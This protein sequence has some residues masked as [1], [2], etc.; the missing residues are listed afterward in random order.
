MLYKIAPD[1][2][3]W[4]FHSGI[5]S[6]ILDLQDFVLLGNWTITATY[7]HRVSPPLRAHAAQALYE[8]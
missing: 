7:G 5:I 8:I 3:T 2:C 6:R 1:L 4:L